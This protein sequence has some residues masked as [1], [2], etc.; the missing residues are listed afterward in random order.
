M[1]QHRPGSAAHPWLGRWP[2]ITHLSMRCNGQTL[3]GS[4]SP[5]LALLK[6]FWHFLPRLPR[7][8]GEVAWGPCGF[9][10]CE[11]RRGQK[12]GL[13]RVV[14]SP[15]CCLFMS[16]MQKLNLWLPGLESEAWWGRVSSFPFPWPW[17]A[18]TLVQSRKGAMIDLATSWSFPRCL[19]L[20]CNSNLKDAP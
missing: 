3:P 2:L 20:L 11:A 6:A 7:V 16:Y 18:L 15:S 10:A 14:V 19:S 5:R 8:C 1:R 13:C 12:W 9:G 4:L 17:C